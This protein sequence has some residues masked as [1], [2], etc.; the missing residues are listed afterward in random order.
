MFSYLHLYIVSNYFFNKKANCFELLVCPLNRKKHWR[1]EIIQGDKLR[2]YFNW[3]GRR[4]WSL[5]F[6]WYR[7]RIWILSPKT[8]APALFHHHN[9]LCVFKGG[10]WGRAGWNGYGAQVISEH[11]M[12][13]GEVWGRARTE[14]MVIRGW[15]GPGERELVFICAEAQTYLIYLN[16]WYPQM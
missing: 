16:Y 1:W 3:P 10:T 15:W 13:C 12:Q 5:G 6:W 8:E 7:N 14:G 2:S 9:K 11:E 4:H